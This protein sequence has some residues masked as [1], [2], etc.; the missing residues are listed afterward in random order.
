MESLFYDA[1]RELDAKFVHSAFSRDGMYEY[2]L[3]QGA[4]INAKDKNGWTALMSACNINDIRMVSRLLELGA[5]IELR[6]NKGPTE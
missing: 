5:A 1:K 6:N 3:N 4:Y 2:W